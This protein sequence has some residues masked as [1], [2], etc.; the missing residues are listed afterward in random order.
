MDGRKSSQEEMV[1]VSKQTIKNAS[2]DLPGGPVIKNPPSN[3]GDTGSIPGRGT[4]IPHAAGQLSLSATTTK[5][6][7]LN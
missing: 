5:L 6:A 7:H 4:K 1:Q 2:G 3:A